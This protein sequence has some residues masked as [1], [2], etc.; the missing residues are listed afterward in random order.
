MRD[1]N[2]MN[3]LETLFHIN[4]F[5]IHDRMKSP[6]EEYD[7][8]IVTARYHKASRSDYSLIMQYFGK[9]NFAFYEGKRFAVW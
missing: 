6:V 9:E 2:Q 3:H 1:I 8:V 5:K 4:G 7:G